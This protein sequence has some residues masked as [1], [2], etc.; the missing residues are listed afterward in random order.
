MPF[1]MHHNIIFRWR[2]IA[3][4]SQPSQCRSI[5]ADG[6]CAQPIAVA[7]ELVLLLVVQQRPVG[8]T[9]ARRCRAR[10]IGATN[11][12]CR[13]TGEQWHRLQFV[14]FRASKIN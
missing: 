5:A 8:R 2:R 12:R 13:A 10:R 4:I 3:T 14:A 11:D 1:V 7:S 9:Q 6:A